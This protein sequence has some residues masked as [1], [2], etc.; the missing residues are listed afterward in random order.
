MVSSTEESL[1]PIERYP[2]VISEQFTPTVEERHRKLFP[3]ITN[4]NPS[5]IF[6]ITLL[7]GQARVEGR[8]KGNKRMA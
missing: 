3:L 7:K 5:Y 4:L 8:I 6:L 2:V 1:L